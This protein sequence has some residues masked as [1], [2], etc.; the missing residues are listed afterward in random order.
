MSSD[1]SPVRTSLQ[2]D[3]PEKLQIPDES[4]LRLSCPSV[5]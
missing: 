4:V 2:R 5:L 3:S 1:K